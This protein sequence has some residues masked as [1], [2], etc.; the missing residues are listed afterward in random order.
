VS[1]SEAQ[2]VEG[3]IDLGQGY[4]L[5]TTDVPR[6]EALATAL[7]VSPG[8]AQLLLRRGLSGA[9]DATRFLDPRLADLTSPL[10]MADRGRACERLAEAVARRE[11]IVVYGDYD[12]DG[13]TSAAIL[14]SILRELGGDVRAYVGNRFEGGYGL[15][16]YALDRALADAPRVL[17]TCDCGSSDHPRVA[18]ARERGVDVVVV[19]HHLVPS[20]PLPAYAFLNPHRP[21]CLFP[22]KGLCSAGLALSVGAGVRAILKSPLDLRRY[23][24]LVALGTIADVAPLTGDNRSLV[25]AGLQLLASEEARAGVRA[26]RESAKI[27]AGAHLSAIDVSFRLTPRLNAPGR[28][29]DS[30]LT[31][32]LLLETDLLRARALAAQIERINL[33]RRALEQRVTEEALLQASA[34]TGAGLVAA[35][36]AFHRG[37]VGITAARLVDKFALPALVVAIDGEVAHGSGRAPDGFPLYTA[38]KRASAHLLKYG[39]HDA[40]VGFSMRA[41]HIPAFREAFAAACAELTR[42]PAARRGTVIDL[43]FGAGGFALPGAAELQRLEPLGEDNPDP[44]CAVDGEVVR[45]SVVGEGHLKLSLRVGERE[46]SAFGY[47]LGH[48]AE[49]LGQRVRAIGFLR[50]DG[51]RGGQHVELKLSALLDGAEPRIAPDAGPSVPPS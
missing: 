39:G 21:D 51:Y 50:P 18:R 31:L 36:E 12:V 37:V 49:G 17:V 5:R 30:A 28:L 38:L 42:A 6:A 29:G 41:E 43:L 15:S 27:R 4:S 10:S 47:Q 11:R 3:L 40:A 35:S 46:L 34:A 14:S 20:E 32:A 44:L 23:L 45:A 48:H 13:T 33:E 8:V 22:F 24:D 19:D 9:E 1:G 16:D 25:R 2:A 7:G 26:L